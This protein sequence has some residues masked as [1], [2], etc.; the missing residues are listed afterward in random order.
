MKKT[1]M[2]SIIGISIIGFF[3]ACKNLTLVL[4]LL[5]SGRV[6]IRS[7]IQIRHTGMHFYS[8]QME[9]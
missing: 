5:D 1:I 4:Q 9:L 2:L 3:S 8:D 7:I 6:N